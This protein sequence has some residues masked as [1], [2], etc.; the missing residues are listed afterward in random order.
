MVTLFFF[1][2]VFYSF[3]SS[4]ALN[5]TLSPGKKNKIEPVF[6]LQADMHAVFSSCCS[7][8]RSSCSVI[9]SW[10]L[11]P[12]HW[13]L[14]CL[15][16]DPSAVTKP[17]A[18][19]VCALCCVPAARTRAA[20]YARS[21]STSDV[22]STGNG[23][24]SPKVIKPTSVLVTVLTSGA[25]TTTITWWVPDLAQQGLRMEPSR[26]LLHHQD[27]HQILW[28]HRLKFPGFIIKEFADIHLNHNNSNTSLKFWKTILCCS[29]HHQLHSFFILHNG[30]NGNSDWPVCDTA[31]LYK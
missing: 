6:R 25:P 22:T 4:P 7:G 15:L 26:S 21:T 24:T 14:P 28:T 11:C 18:I 5:F 23:S 31:R 12:R 16:P 9:T 30:L 13:P 3:L 2:F 1:P 27:R 20:A 17:V 8:E 10:G 19:Y 29:L